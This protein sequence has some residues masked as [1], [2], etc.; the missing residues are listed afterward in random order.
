[1][2]GKLKFL[3]GVGVGYVLGTRAGRERYQ[4][5]K[6][7]AR[8]VWHDPRV[9]DKADHAQGVIKE[10]ASEVGSA[11]TTKVTNKV[12]SH[13]SHGSSDVH[14]DGSPGVTSPGTTTG[15]HS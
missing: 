9:Q 7:K 4:Q 10:K 13:G 1:M 5:I 14:P 6:T 2:V 15:R 12:G 8:G 11:V 3:A